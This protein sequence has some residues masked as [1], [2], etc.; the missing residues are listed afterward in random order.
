MTGVTWSWERVGG[1][2]VMPYMQGRSCAGAISEIES[3]DDFE[4]EMEGC[5]FVHVFPVFHDIPEFTGLSYELVWP[6]DWSD[7]AFTSCSDIT[8]GDI[9]RPGDAVSQSWSSCRPGQLVIAGWAEVFSRSPGRV[10][11]LGAGGGNPEIVT[12]DGRIIT[13]EWQFACGVCGASGDDPP[14]GGGPTSVAPTT[15]GGIK[16]IFR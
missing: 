8:V 3:C 6:E 11:M 15:W 2:H 16:S 12:C 4:T 13:T 14:C 5:G 9:V 7:M 10:E 1:L